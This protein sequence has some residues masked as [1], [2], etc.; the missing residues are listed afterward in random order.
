MVCVK[1][2]RG[3]LARM[4]FFPDVPKSSRQ[5]ERSFGLQTTSRKEASQFADRVVKVLRFPRPLTVKVTE[6]GSKV[7]RWHH[8]RVCEAVEAVEDS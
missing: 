7:H 8:P 6:D 5:P 3:T 4:L 1:G 2:W